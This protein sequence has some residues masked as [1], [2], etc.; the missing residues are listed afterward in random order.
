MFGR[1]KTPKSKKFRLCQLLLVLALVP[2]AQACL[3]PTSLVKQRD[4]EFRQAQA[5]FTDQDEVYSGFATVLLASG[6]YKSPAFRQAYVRKYAADYRFDQAAEDEMMTRELARGEEAMEFILAL[7]TPDRAKLRLE[8]HDSLWRVYLQTGA[9][10]QIKPFEIRPINNQRK[11]LE[12]YYPY[13]TAWVD[14][15]RVTFLTAPPKDG[16][17]EIRLVVTG[18]MGSA[19]LSFGRR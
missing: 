18:V 10:E 1:I 8:G 2:L 6:T 14:L 4:N 7:Y 19:S 3:G 11:T 15:Y 17:A 12:E 13:V 5:R 9:D 16:E